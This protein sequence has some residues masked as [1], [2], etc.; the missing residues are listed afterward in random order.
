MPLPIAITQ[1][2]KRYTNKVLRLLA[3]HGSFVE[4]EHVGRKSGTLR[5]IPINAMFAPDR[6]TVTCA[7]TYGPRVDWYRNVCAA[8]GCRMRTKHGVITLGAPRT[9]TREEG[10]VR[11]PFPAPVILK[12]AGVTDFIE[13]PVTEIDSSGSSW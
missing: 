10:L 7:L 3:G 1:F 13:M 5:R 9:L 8:G 2:N 4:L 6:R 12:L 11:M